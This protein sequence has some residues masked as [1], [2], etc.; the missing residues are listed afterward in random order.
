M[1]VADRFEAVAIVLLVPHALVRFDLMGLLAM[2]LFAVGARILLWLLNFLLFL[3]P[4]ATLRLGALEFL[5][6]ACA[7]LAFVL[8]RVAVRAYA[9]C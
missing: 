1:L 9:I 5:V 3:F 7:W 6:L 4:A 2:E 8:G